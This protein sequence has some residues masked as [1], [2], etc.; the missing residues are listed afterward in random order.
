VTTVAGL[1]EHSTTD[2]QRMDSYLKGYVGGQ[3]DIMVIKGLP[4]GN[5]DVFAIELK[6]PKGTGE[7]SAK[8]LEYHERLLLKCHVKTFISSNYEEIVIALHEH[9]REFSARAQILAIADKKEEEY[10]FSTNSNPKYWLN[11]LKNKATLI[12]ECKKRGIVID[13]ALGTFNTKI[14]EI[15]IA[16]DSS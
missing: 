6:N 4:N 9:Y 7:L 12:N 1:G 2:H 5:Q 10:D 8:Q 16:A 13:N 3:P 15:L 11:R 14:I